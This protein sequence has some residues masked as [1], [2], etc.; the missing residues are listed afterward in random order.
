MKVQNG[1]IQLTA[2]PMPIGRSTQKS[3]QNF[4]AYGTA[5]GLL[6]HQTSAINKENPS[7]SGLVT[8]S[9][10]SRPKKSNGIKQQ[11]YLQTFTGSGF[12]EEE[13]VTNHIVVNN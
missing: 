12:F 3:N 5:T 1:V 2:S 13:K 8:N 11:G 10:A 4:K 9:L 6:H 7:S